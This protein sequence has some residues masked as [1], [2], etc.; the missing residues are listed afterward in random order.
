MRDWY[1]SPEQVEAE[2]Y[3]AAAAQ[4]RAKRAKLFDQLRDLVDR[5]HSQVRLGKEPTDSLE[6]LDNIAQALRDVTEQPGFPYDV[7]WPANLI[8]QTVSDT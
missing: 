6:S 8:S 1:K 2:K 3:D 7:Q 5:H 4:V